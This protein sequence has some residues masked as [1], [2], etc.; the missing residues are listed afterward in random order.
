MVNDVILTNDWHVVGR[1][2]DLSPGKILTVR[3]LGVDLVLWRCGDQTL[4]WEDRCPHRGVS[5]AKGWV[6]DDNLIC[7]YHGFAFNNSGQCVH[8][9]AHPN[10]LLSKLSRGCVKTFHTQERYGMI[11][12]CLGTPQTEIPPFL[13]WEDTSY[14]RSFFGPTRYQ[15]S[16]LR[17]IEN[18]FDFSH[19]PFVHGGTLSKPEH[20]VMDERY[21][22]KV[23]SDGINVSEVNVWQFDIETGQEICVIVDYCIFRPLTVCLRSNDSNNH[24][25]AIFFT[26]TPVDEEECIA[27]RWI[28]L[29]HAHH[30]P[31][32]EMNH[33]ADAIMYQDV[34]IVEAQRPRRLPLDLQAEFHVASDHSSI[35]YRKW[36]KQLGVTF[37]AV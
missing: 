11:W 9:P 2:Q 15:A 33:L 32:T 4:A 29:N 20:A 10:Q 26:V 31:E 25:M 3:L 35:T 24:R 13:E 17:A 8:V 23:T 6:K 27:W 37:G 28:F 18:F 36:L 22:V 14:R 19:I 30:I 12:V 34:D 5:F 1:S 7:P 21:K 16:G